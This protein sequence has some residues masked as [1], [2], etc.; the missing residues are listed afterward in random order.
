[1]RHAVRGFF[2]RLGLEVASVSDA[3]RSRKRM[4]HHSHSWSIF[5]ALPRDYI[6]RRR[7]TRRISNIIIVVLLSAAVAYA[8]VHVSGP[9]AFSVPHR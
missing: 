7:A 6:R 1:M 3:S 8:I 4:P 5:P 9:A 2:E